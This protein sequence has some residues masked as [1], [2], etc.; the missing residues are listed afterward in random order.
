LTD[1]DEFD[2]PW[3]MILEGYV[4][5]FL[6]FFF[7]KVHAAIDWKRGYEFL[8]KELQSITADGEI[9][10]RITDKLIKVWHIDG[11][12]AWILI[13]IEV[14]N[15]YDP[16]FAERMFVY[17]YRLFDRFRKRVVSLAVLGDSGM[18]WRPTSFGYELWDCSIAFQFPIVKLIDYR[19]T[20]DALHTN[21]NPF[22]TVILAHLAAQ[23]TRQDDTARSFAKYV[24]TRR[25][26]QLGYSRQNILD[27][28]RF[29][30]WILRLPADLDR[31]IW[32]QIRDYE[33]EQQMTYISTAERVGLQ[34][35]LEQG[36]QQGLE[37]G[38]Q[39][40]LEQGRQQGLEQGRQQ[41]LEQ[42]AVETT[43][44]LTLD[45]AYKMFGPLDAELTT[46]ISTLPATTAHQL[47]L[48]LV[49]FTQTD[50]LRQWLHDNRPLNHEPAVEPRSNG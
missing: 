26:Y 6:A 3:K 8:D 31:Q 50:E 43:R 45:L 15:Q 17:H 46:A 23:D 35:G 37:Q 7:P 21:A 28:Y 13:H 33:E 19:S 32:Q 20:Q 9:G 44:N 47:L 25:L 29:I 18:T 5:D 1:H 49:D 22:A 36:R 12:E 34:Q 41:G 38:R 2:G 48:K 4:P 14:Q 16:H 24:L 40:G 27:L 11:N 30:D 10:V 39:Q 42:G